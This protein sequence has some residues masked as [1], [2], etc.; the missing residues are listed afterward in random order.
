M[1]MMMMMILLLSMTK[2]IINKMLPSWVEQNPCT[3]FI[4]PS[5]F[6]S[7]RTFFYSYMIHDFNTGNQAS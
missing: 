7:C 5:L 6:S 1:M 3:A 4:R 2:A